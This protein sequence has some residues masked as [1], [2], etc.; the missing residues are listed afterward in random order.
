MKLLGLVSERVFDGIK[1]QQE[2]FILNPIVHMSDPKSK[3]GKG[4]WR[5][6]QTLSGQMKS[7]GPTPSPRSD[8]ITSLGTPALKTQGESIGK[9]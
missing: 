7:K 9:G 3:L 2:L 6:L 4:R 5:Q 8:K 1:H